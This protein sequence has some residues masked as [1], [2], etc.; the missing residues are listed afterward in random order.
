MKKFFLIIWFLPVICFSQQPTFRFFAEIKADTVS[1][2]IVISSENYA[3]TLLGGD[4]VETFV[5]D[6]T[7]NY[8]GI[9]DV[10]YPAL[11]NFSK[12]KPYPSWYLNDHCH[13]QSPIV[14]PNDGRVYIWNEAL[15]IW[16]AIQ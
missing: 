1:R 9:G 10:F 2:V 16:E 8:A 3:E 4:W 14:H 13:W 7:K 6:T 11:N 15:K 12:P 5:N